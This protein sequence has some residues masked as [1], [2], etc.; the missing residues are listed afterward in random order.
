MSYEVRLRPAAQR[1]LDA[2]SGRDYQMLARAIATLEANPRPLRVTK[3]AGSDLWR[4]RVGHY[5]IVYAIDD[6]AQVVSV[7]R[8]ARRREDTYEGL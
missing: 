3:L 7:V 6:R 5:R 8:I 4:I 2:I 1:S